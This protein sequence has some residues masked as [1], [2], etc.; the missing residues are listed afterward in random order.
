MIV[1]GCNLVSAMKVKVHIAHTSETCY[2]YF[3]NYLHQDWYWLCFT[4]SVCLTICLRKI[5]QSCGEFWTFW[6]GAE[7]MTSTF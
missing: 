4:L 1:A 7:C 2:E 6:R 5:T 3:T